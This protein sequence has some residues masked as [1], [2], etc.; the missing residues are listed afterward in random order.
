MTGEPQLRLD[1]L[2][3]LL[4]ALCEGT[5]D[6]DGIAHLEALLA[7]DPAAHRWYLGYLDLHV[8]LSWDHLGGKRAGLR[9]L[10]AGDWTANERR[11]P[12][13]AR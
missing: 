9:G 12:N 5:I 3:P 2:S 10:L 8:D 7:A 1:E 13:D 11:V 6:A 4:A